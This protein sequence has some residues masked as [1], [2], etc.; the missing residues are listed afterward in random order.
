MSCGREVIV[1]KS[2]VQEAHEEAKPNIFFKTNLSKQKQQDHACAQ[3]KT[4]LFFTK[5]QHKS[6]IFLHL[7][8]CVRPKKLPNFI[9]LHHNTIKYQIYRIGPNDLAVSLHFIV[10][11]VYETVN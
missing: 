7:A 2:R 8:A 5:K 4:I 10:D 1:L 9:V 6:M 11:T 3:H